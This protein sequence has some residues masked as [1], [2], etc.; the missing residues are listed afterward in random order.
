MHKRHLFALITITAALASGCG[1]LAGGRHF[2]GS[3][4]LASHDLFIA[5]EVPAC[6]QRLGNGA[7]QTGMELDSSRIRL[8]SWNVKKGQLAGWQEDLDALAADQDLVLMQEAMWHP[9]DLPKMHYWAFAP[10]YRTGKLLSGVMTYS[11]SEPLTQCNL[12]SWEPWLR[13]PK[14]TNI[15]EF[16]LTGTDETVLVV[17]IHAINFTFGVA[18]FRTQLEQIR[19]VLAMHGGPII[20]SGDFNT[21]RKK[22]ADI[23]ESFTAE[24]SLKPVDFAD[25]YRKVFFG[26]PLDYIYVRGLRTGASGTRRL[27]SSDHNPLLAEFSL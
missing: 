9:D 7:G 21:W 8:V 26:Q 1:T 22:R 2:G 12:T 11:S 24:F 23:L 10:G 5:S 13:T 16:G 3:E 4:L 17:N 27:D 15:T 14:A 18:D 6:L 25:D 19:P 20:L